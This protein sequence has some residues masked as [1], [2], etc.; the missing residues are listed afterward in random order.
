ML[1]FVA[2]G[3]K[4]KLTVEG[5]SELGRDGKFKIDLPVGEVMVGVD[6]REF[7][8]MPA[9]GPAKLPGENLPEDVRK[10]WG[11]SSPPKTIP[12]VQGGPFREW[13][14]AIKGDGPEP[15]SNF[16]VSAKL[17]EIILLGVLAQRFHTRIEWD[18]KAG[19]ITNH[20]E[21]NAF[22]KEPA[23][24]GWRFGETL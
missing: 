4:E 14:R 21:L 13:I 10:A 5:S 22:V 8:P 16:R 24:E 20:P 23:R 2:I 17:T 15:G 19:Q 18:S 11:A 1:S 6:N 9:T 12:R 7:E 3:P